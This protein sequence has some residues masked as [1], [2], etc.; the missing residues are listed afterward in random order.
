MLIFADLAQNCETVGG[1]STQYLR[2]MRERR[3]RRT[4]DHLP[5]GQS[6]SSACSC[7]PRR[8]HRTLE[9]LFPLWR[10]SSRRDERERQHALG[11][12]GAQSLVHLLLAY[13]CFLRVREALFRS[14][15]PGMW[16]LSAPKTLESVGSR[17]AVLNRRYRS[18][19]AT[20]NS[21]SRNTIQ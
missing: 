16:G 11:P 7:P 5:A 8:R 15:S 21:S 14:R 12:D 9:L 4:G 17:S 13:A 20:T 19:I 10:I 2:P 6:C 1:A 18:P 3:D